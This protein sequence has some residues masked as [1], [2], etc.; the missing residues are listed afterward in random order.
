MVIKDFL[1]MGHADNIIAMFKQDS[2]LFAWTGDLLRDE[3]FVVR[4]GLVLIFEELAALGHKEIKLAIP[5][6]APLIAADIPAYIRGEAVTILGIIGTTEALRLLRP[7]QND[8][9]PQVR[10]I[11]EDIL[12]VKPTI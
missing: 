8:T 7:L 3:R 2:S 9:D 4:L 1:E 12:A 6:L 10:E 11:T 5:A